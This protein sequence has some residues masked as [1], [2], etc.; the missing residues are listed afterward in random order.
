MLAARNG[1]VVDGWA[2]VRVDPAYE[3]EWHLRQADRAAERAHRKAIDPY[4]YGHW[5]PSYDE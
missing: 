4:N 3:R 1:R 2:E 5:G